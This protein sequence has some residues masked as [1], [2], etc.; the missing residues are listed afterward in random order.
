MTNVLIAT[1]EPMLAEGFE[2]ILTTAGLD[3][4]EICRD[5]VQLFDAVR[6]SRPDV[7]LLDS[8]MPPGIHLL[9]ELRREW[10][11]SQ[12]LLW[13]RD[14]SSLDPQAA[15]GFG[16]RGVLPSTTSPAQLTEAVHMV[17]LFPA[18]RTATALVNHV[19]D[20]AE[21]QLIGCLGRGMNSDEIAAVMHSDQA[22]VD[23]QVKSIADRLGVRDR[24]EL[25]LYGLSM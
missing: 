12:L 6:R 22:T 9:V 19:C 21:R 17:T 18:G 24:Y 15:I 16:A 2:T 3:V 5:A 1:P 14:L 4:V 20:Q 7:I 8:R 25:A 13:V 10:P 23:R 11:C